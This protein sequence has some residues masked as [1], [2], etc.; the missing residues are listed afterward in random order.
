MTFEEADAGPVPQALTAVTVYDCA[1]PCSWPISILVDAV[2]P[3][4]P[5]EDT[6]LY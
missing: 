1:V 6:Q 3:D 4:F 5:S 2:D